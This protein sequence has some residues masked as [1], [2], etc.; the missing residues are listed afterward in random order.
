MNPKMKQGTLD[1][2]ILAVLGRGSLY[3]LGI[4]KAVNVRSGGA[5][6]FKEGSLYPALHRLVKAG[7]VTAHWQSS[8]S[9]GAPRKYYTLTSEG[10]KALNKKKADWR[11]L[12]S[13]VDSVVLKEV[14]S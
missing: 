13:A 11:A 4:L 8:T 6:E 10:Q 3:G 14:I 12:R 7:F 1:L 5:F 9:G 2:M